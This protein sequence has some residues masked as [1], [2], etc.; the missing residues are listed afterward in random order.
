MYGYKKLYQNAAKYAA[1]YQHLTD[2]TGYCY[3]W[4]TGSERTDAN[5]TI[6]LSNQRCKCIKSIAFQYQCKHEL[7]VDQKFILGK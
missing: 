7:A 2:G 3:V 5:C 1:N 6:I 4:P